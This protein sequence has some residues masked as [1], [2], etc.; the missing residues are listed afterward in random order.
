MRL[1]TAIDL[2]ERIRHKLAATLNK[3]RPTAKINWS[4]P[5]NLHIT[6]KFIGEWDF[7]RMDELEAALEAMPKPDPFEV[8]VRGVGYFP[9]PHSPRTLFAGVEA[10]DQ[11]NQLAAA[12]DSALQPLGIERESRKYSPHLTLARLKS[13]GDLADLRAAVAALPVIDFGSFTVDSF[14]LFE[15]ELTSNGSIYTKV[16]EFPFRQP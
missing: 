8:H 12:I 3:L 2:P 4:P 9:T 1:F 16:A 5:A 7:D 11:L 14:D 13:T 6:T 10:P 15:S